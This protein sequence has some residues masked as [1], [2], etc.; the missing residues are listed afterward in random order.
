MAD[1]DLINVQ[2]IKKQ[3][4]MNILQIITCFICHL[5]T[6]FVKVSFNQ[7]SVRLETQS[8]ESTFYPDVLKIKIIIVVKQ[9]LYKCH[10]F[11]I[12]KLTNPYLAIL[13]LGRPG[14]RVARSWIRKF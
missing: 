14:I 5:K 12:Y 1:V 11:I 3:I 7:R 6:Q 2:T 8:V 10:L 9:N 13:Q 4:V